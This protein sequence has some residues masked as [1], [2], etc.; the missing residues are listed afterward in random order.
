MDTHIV[1]NPGAVPGAFKLKN[2]KKPAM[3]AHFGP[4]MRDH[5][6]LAKPTGWV[7]FWRDLGSF[8][9]LQIGW[10]SGSVKARFGPD[11]CTVDEAFASW[12]W[13]D[14]LTIKVPAGKNRHPSW[15][16][17]F[18]H[19]VLKSTPWVDVASCIEK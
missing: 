7:G 18:G 3:R 15:P 2:V 1:P 9:G 13:Y 12:Q 17:S 11:M 4:A 19:D 8:F 5:F 14:Y 16:P 10:D 6:G